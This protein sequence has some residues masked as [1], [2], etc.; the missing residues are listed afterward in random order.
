MQQCLPCLHRRKDVQRMRV[1]SLS[2]NKS[3][4]EGNLPTEEAKRL[5][6]RRNSY[7]AMQNHPHC[8]SAIIV[9]TTT[10]PDT[11]LN[12]SWAWRSRRCSRPLESPPCEC[13]AGSRPSPR[14]TR[15]RW[16][17]PG[18]SWRSPPPATRRIPAT[19]RSAD[20][21]FRTRWCCRPPARPWGERLWERRWGRQWPGG[22][23][24]P[25]LVR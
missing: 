10:A 22:S 11:S 16:S 3:L 7:D 15:S 14:P 1:A 13:R 18:C 12:L 4:L 20:R 24:C 5:D 23:R 17:R 8:T 25:I 2:L 9:I 6:M 19:V 21:D